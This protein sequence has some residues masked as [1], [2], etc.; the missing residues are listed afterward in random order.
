MD[1]RTY[2]ENLKARLLA[3]REALSAQLAAVG[4]GVAADVDPTR[5][6]RLTRLDDLHNQAMGAESIRRRKRELA[7][8]DAALHRLEDGEYGECAAC[9][10]P[11][12]PARLQVDPAAEWC[13]R[14]ATRAEEQ[15]R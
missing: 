7:R 12:A 11:I 4:D 15:R 8:I 1:R 3:Q 6:G 10:E 14:C 13:I 5:A 2:S 9:G